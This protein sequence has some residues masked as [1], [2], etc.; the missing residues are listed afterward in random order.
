MKYAIQNYLGETILEATQEE[1]NSLLEKATD[2]KLNYFQYDADNDLVKAWETEK[3][4][5]DVSNFR[6]YKELGA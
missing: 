3:E 6:I 2:E 4:T 1:L 5:R